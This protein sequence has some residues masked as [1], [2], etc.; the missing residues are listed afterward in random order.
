MVKSEMSRHK[1]TRTFQ[2]NCAQY[3]HDR[4]RASFPSPSPYHTSQKRLASNEAAN[5]IF[6]GTCDDDG[7]AGRVMREPSLV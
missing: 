3:L 5:R 4:I 2:A 7:H 1:V 6:D